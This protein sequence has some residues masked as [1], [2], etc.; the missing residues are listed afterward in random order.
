M[1]VISCGGMRFQHGWKEDEEIPAE[2][3]RNVEACARR[4]L[5]LG[6]THLETARGYGTSEAQ[7]GK[8]L[9]DLD[10]DS[11]HLQ[12]K[13]GPHKDVSK[14]V[15]DFEK[16][17]GLLRVDHLDLMAIHGINDDDSFEAFEG[18][19]ETAL[20]W[21]EEGRI[22]NLGFATH[23]PTDIITKAIATDVFDYVNLH[24]YYVFQDNW[25]AIEE[26]TKRDMGVFIISPNDKGGKLYEPS[27][28]LL[29]LCAPFHPMVFNG[30]FCLSHP[31][32]HTLSC[33]VSCPGDFD[34][35]LETAEK[36][37]EAAALV[38]PIVQRL[39]EAMA[40]TLG[41]AWQK[42]WEEGLP[43]W[44]QTPG[45]INIPW[46]LRLRNL[47]RAYDM[48]EYGKMRYNFLGNGDSWFPGEQCGKAGEFDFSEA[49]SKS[50]HAKEIP[51]YLLEAHALLKGEEVK[52]L[53][54]DE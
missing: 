38:A 31:E 18:C 48:V 36:V 34:I 24:W 50:P 16:S 20:K 43:Q 41:E 10:R 8:F 15:S 42:T 5:E 3:D 26:A 39:E 4:A 19:L 25:P 47:A 13:I 23:G 37:D 53:Q 9:P 21:K 46:I 14:F 51:G 54:Q 30:L 32:I 17:M 27:D 29:E 49:L 12:T 1:P 33:G 52:R 6:I 28:K 44:H 35:H 40:E 22:R 45:N 11:F 7:M 2:S